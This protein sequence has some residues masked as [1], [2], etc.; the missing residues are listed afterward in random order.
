M[1]ERKQ[2]SQQ[3]PPPEVFISSFLMGETIIQCG[4]AYYTCGLLFDKYGSVNFV[5]QRSGMSFVK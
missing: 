4:E 1:G 3:S 2:S 5:W